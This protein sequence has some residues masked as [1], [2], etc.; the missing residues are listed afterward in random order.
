MLPKTY[1]F[2]PDLI[3]SLDRDETGTRVA[4]MR[5]MPGDGSDLKPA[6]HLETGIPHF[7]EGSTPGIA[8]A[9]GGKLTQFQPAHI[10]ID[11]SVHRTAPWDGGFRAVSLIRYDGRFNPGLQDRETGRVFCDHDAVL[12]DADEAFHIARHRLS[13]DTKIGDPVQVT[14]EIPDPDEEEW[15]ASWIQTLA[16]KIDDAVEARLEYAEGHKDAGDGYTHLPREGTWAYDNGDDRL[17]KYLLKAGIDMNGLEPDEVSELVLDN[18]RMEPGTIIDPTHNNDD[19]FLVS[20]FP[21]GEIEEQ[22]S[23]T[24]IMPTASDEDWEFAKT[25]SGVYF[26]DNGLAYAVSDRVWYA[27]IDRSDLEELISDRSAE[28]L[29]GI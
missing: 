13:T 16:A 5:T 25:E 22:I 7:M 18:F 6:I 27:V 28:P 11:P 23:K 12:E 4:A 1:P 26:G 19:L 24:D 8:I 21:V 15:N 10:L 29:P 17:K 14:D 20:S 2:P 9:Q 3:E